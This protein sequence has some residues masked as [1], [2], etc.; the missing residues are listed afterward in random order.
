M[1][2][3]R[4][5]LLR[6]VGR[7][8]GVVL[9]ICHV[10][11]AY[12]A[13]AFGTLLGWTVPGWL[14][15]LSALAGLGAA[16]TLLRARHRLHVPVAL[17]L[18]MWIAAVLSG[19]LREENLVRCDD[20]LSLRPPVRLVVPNPQLASCL[21]AEVRPSGRFPRTIW[22]APD[23]KR[24]VFTTQGAVVPGGIDGAICE[25]RLDGGV[26]PRC[27]GPPLNKSQ[28]L[29]E[30]P[31]EGRLLAM[32][33][34]IQTPEGKRGSV[35]YELPRDEGI[36]ILGEHWFEEP[37][38][39]GF[40]EPRNSTLYLF[41]DRR[42]KIYRARL[43]SFKPAPALAVAFAPGELHYDP[44][45]GEGVA[46]GSPTG[47]ALRG[48]PFRLR[49]FADGSSSL[50]DKLSLTWGCDWDQKTR[51]VFTTIP[52]LGFLYRIDYDTGR[53]EKR[54]WVGLGM[55]SVAYDRPRK[56]VYFTNFLR[57]EVLA[58]DERSER[59]VGRWFVGRFSRW[60]RLTR[61][62]HALL[63]TG[64]LGI[65]RIPLDGEGGESTLT[66]N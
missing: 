39:D 33:W 40:Y 13:V 22:E 9:V 11:W 60:V 28:G 29:I 43:P 4:S 3:H 21:Q 12:L 30:L 35:I 37:I 14:V 64:N 18:G 44:G 61:D 15:I 48:E 66:A 26:A 59:I 7:A 27:I 42:D 51:K 24:V 1:S 36:A 32:Q 62:G 52:N 45:A 49:Y 55:R 65:V 20:F 47:V 58:F 46:C 41:S 34:S 8:C 38:G 17:P 25:A 50:L 5:H 6:W 23:G 56:R 31:E 63:A 10:L 2:R 19:W 53:V 54:W 57:G 16:A